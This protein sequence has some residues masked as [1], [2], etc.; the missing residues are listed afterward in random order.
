MRH[1]GIQ[2]GSCQEIISL[3]EYDIKHWRLSL[4]IS[5]YTGF[6]IDAQEYIERSASEYLCDGFLKGCELWIVIFYDGK[7]T[8]F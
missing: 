8:F 6:C 4:E 2:Y 1:W 3:V 5:L 7:N